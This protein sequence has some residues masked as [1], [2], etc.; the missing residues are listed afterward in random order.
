M[1]QCLFFSDR[2][3]LTYSK[4]RQMMMIQSVQLSLLGSFCCSNWIMSMLR[5]K[6]NNSRLTQ[7]FFLLFIILNKVWLFLCV[8]TVCPTW[9]T[10]GTGFEWSQERWGYKKGEKEEKADGR[11]NVK[12]QLN[13]E[14]RVIEGRYKKAEKH[15]REKMRSQQCVNYYPQSF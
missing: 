7:L 8:T 11:R 10:E 13:K 15:F 2:I 5:A 3:H 1:K 12:T 6:K 14:G 4:M 9:T